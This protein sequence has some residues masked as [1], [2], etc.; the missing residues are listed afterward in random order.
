MQTVKLQYKGYRIKAVI[1]LFDIHTE[2]Q[3]NG[4]ND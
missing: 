2:F 1:K 3:D 4:W